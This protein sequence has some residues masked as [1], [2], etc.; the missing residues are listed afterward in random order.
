[1]NFVI[2][3]I[4]GVIFLGQ[5]SAVDGIECYTCDVSPMYDYSQGGPCFEVS[6]ETET[7]K[8]CEYCRMNVVNETNHC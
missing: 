2:V 8:Y 1:M 4:F 6:E 7:K 3:L 5:H